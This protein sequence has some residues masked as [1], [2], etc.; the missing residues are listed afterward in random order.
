MKIFAP[1]YYKKF[2][3]IGSSCRHNCCIGW[4]IG[5]DED[6]LEKYEK[7]GGKLG[8]KLKDN[9]EIMPDGAVFR[10]DRNERC[11]F[12]NRKNLCEIILSEGEN[13]LCEICTD[14]PRFRNYFSDR[15]ETGLGLCCEEAG[16]LILGQKNKMS[17]TEYGENSDIP[18]YCDEE[19]DFFAFRDELFANIQNRNTPIS[20]RVKDLR[21]RC[22]MN[23]SFIDCIDLFTSLEIL[24]K[25]W[26]NLLSE[27]KNS[28]YC[29]S[30]ETEFSPFETEFEQLLMYFVYRHLP[31][32][33]EGYGENS[34]LRF[35]LLLYSAVTQIFEYESRVKSKGDFENLV[36]I[37]RALS[38]ETEYSQENTDILIENA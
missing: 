20:Q 29:F 23:N 15:V 16:R 14:H 6:T 9:I 17:L 19:N 36:E 22:G 7:I 30:E 32:I 33:T 13:A 2:K 25:G 1:D 21:A 4:E 24:D 11:P 5:I 10:L 12:L 18:Y 26:L 28:N 3:C 34:I 8:Q 31:K 27:I 37:S 35:I 38:A